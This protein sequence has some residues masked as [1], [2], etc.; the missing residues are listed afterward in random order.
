[1]QSGAAAGF[2]EIAILAEKAVAWMHRVGAVG[3][4]GADDRW[5][6]EIAGFGLRGPD[7]YGLIRHA[8]MQGVLVRGRVDREGGNAQLAARA[9]YADRDGPAIGNQQLL[10]H[11]A[12]RIRRPP[13]S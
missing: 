12:R 7:A 1:M 6:V 4:C 11:R 2:G 13:E 5:N 8:H 10:E 3:G 9:D